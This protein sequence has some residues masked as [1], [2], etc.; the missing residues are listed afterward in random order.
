MMNVY[1]NNFNNNMSSFGGMRNVNVPM[2]NAH[3]SS[4]NPADTPGV[5][6]DDG[7][8]SLA[9]ITRAAFGRLRS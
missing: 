5:V 8:R 1:P 9:Q 4:K 6:V 2:M 7:Q 3:P